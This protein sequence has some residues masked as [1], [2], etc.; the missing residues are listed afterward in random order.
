M[1]QEATEWAVCEMLLLL[2]TR[3]E[4]EDQTDDKCNDDGACLLPDARANKKLKVGIIDCGCLVI[5]LPPERSVHCLNSSLPKFQPPLNFFIITYYGY[6]YMYSF[7][8]SAYA[9]KE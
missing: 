7:K 9:R 1:V 4:K 3:I 8:T 6:Y 2:R 5:K